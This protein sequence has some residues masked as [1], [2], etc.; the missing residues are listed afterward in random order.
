MH[1]TAE[2]KLTPVSNLT[3]FFRDALGE[4]L[5][6]Q[7]VSLD[8]HTAHYVVSLLTLYSRTEVSHGDTR[9]G[10]RWVSLAELLAQAADART[11]AERD[12][13]LQRLGDVSL[14]VAGF[15]AHGFERRLVDVDYHVAMGGRAYSTLACANVSGPRRA[16]NSVFGEL[17]RK[18]QSVVDAIGEIS[19]TA[20]VWSSKDVLRLYELWL[21][22]G[23]PRAQGLLQQLG[24]A[25]APV[26]LRT[27]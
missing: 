22:T 3:E 4:A 16:L 24:V 23:S 6:H 8:E 19:D 11:P 15:F 10:Q 1:S 21:K 26:S 7:H 9:P 2:G 27:S 13:T 25:P 17:A 20:R 5:T 18:F 14:F 12:A